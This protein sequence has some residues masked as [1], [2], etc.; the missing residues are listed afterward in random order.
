L[1]KSFGA[2]LLAILASILVTTAWSACTS[3]Q[4]LG[5][6]SIAKNRVVLARVAR[7]TL[8]LAFIG[9]YA[10][11][12]RKTRPPFLR[13]TGFVPAK[14]A[15]GSYAAGFL[16]GVIPVVALIVALVLIGARTFA[17]PTLDGGLA[18]H[19]TKYVLAG[20]VLVVVEEGL[21]RGL[22]LGDLVRASDARTGVI[23]CSALFAV[24]HFLGVSKAWRQVPIPDPGG[25]DVLVATFGGLGRMVRDWP[26]LVGLFLVGLILA[27]LRLRSG[28]LYLGMGIH[29][30]WFWVKQVDHRF[31]T[32]VDS[33]AG[34]A[35]LWLGSELYLDGVLGWG[36]LLV[37]LFLALT[38]RLG[39][40]PPDHLRESEP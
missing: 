11:L 3:R 19:L 31:V 21:F 35:R 13:A 25:I 20:V 32:S 1:R 39:G 18:W 15:V 34:P 7:L 27:I 9:A 4:D 14:G 2:V 6:D 33:V 38:L 17:P 36:A 22:L 29:A 28:S 26:Q 12:G 23:A 37:T 8:L 24:T 10:L 16:A 40:N 5:P 30:G